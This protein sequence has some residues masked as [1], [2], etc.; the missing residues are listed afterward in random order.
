MRYAALIVIGALSLAAVGCKEAEEAGLMQTQAEIEEAGLGRYGTPGD[1]VVDLTG[2]F[3]SAPTE[4]LWNGGN[5]SSCRVT[6]MRDE[7]T[8][9]V[10][11][12]ESLAYQNG[13][14][15]SWNSPGVGQAPLCPVA[16]FGMPRY[17]IR[18]I[19]GGSAIEICNKRTENHLTDRWIPGPTHCRTLMRL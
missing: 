16:A 6:F 18:I 7:A 1:M 17:G 9:D 12:T 2:D 19:N 15:A 5:G 14:W 4:R 13:Q 8:G 11:V 10:Y 3:S